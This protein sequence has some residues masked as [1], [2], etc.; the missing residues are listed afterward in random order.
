MAERA[1]PST[2]IRWKWV[3]LCLVFGGVFWGGAFLTQAEFG[4]TGIFPDWMLH[5]GTAIGLAGVLF[6]LEQHFT[7]SVTAATGKLVQEAEERVET[8]TRELS[9]R[10]DKLG[11]QFRSGL[12]ARNVAQDAAI[13]ALESDV[14]FDTV[15][16]A[17]E[18][19]NDIGALANGFATVQASVDPDELALEFRW[20]TTSWPPGRSDGFAP[21]LS[22]QAEPDFS[23]PGDHYVIQVVWA[24]DQPASEVGI[25]LAE[26]LQQRNRWK[27][28]GTLDWQQTIQNLIRTLDV[29]IKSQRRTEGAWNLHGP[30]IELVGDNWALTDAGIECPDKGYVFPETEF[31]ERGG[32]G[33]FGKPPPE[34][35]PAKPNWADDA[36]WQRLLRRG[37]KVF[38]R[39]RGPARFASGSQAM[40]TTLR[41]TWR[42]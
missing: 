32:P 37:K 34:W 12:E 41:N 5:V 29:A 23:T 39:N 40:T 7:T 11:E 18:V 17:L 27:G 14:S 9:T 38:P 13:A 26:Q 10:L 35:A 1:R 30:L 31:P 19:A 25:A 22:V 8:K 20:W 2:Q 3:V 4:W 16:R 15:T 28:P 24:P 21:E 33:R 36:E 42:V 6:L